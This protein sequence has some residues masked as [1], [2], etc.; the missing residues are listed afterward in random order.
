MRR[1]HALR[2][3]EGRPPEPK[4]SWKPLVWTQVA[5]D[6]FQA[7]GIPLLRGRYFNAQDGAESGPVAIVNETL[8][9]RY[10]PGEDPVGKRVKGFDPRGKHDDW[11]TVVGE[12]RDTR[13]GGLDKTPFSQMYEVQAQSGEQLG[14]LV[15]RTAGDPAPLAAAAR[16]LIHDADPLATV[17]SIESMEQLLD[18]QLMQRRFETWLIGV[19]SAMALALAALGVFAVMHYSVTAKRNEIGIRVAL[20]ARAG[21]IV[22]LI[23]SQG[24]QLACAG[25]AAGAIIAMWSTGAIRGMLYQVSATDPLTFLAAGLTL[26]AV[27]LFACFGPAQRASRIDPMAALR[28][29]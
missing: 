27:A 11:L 15:V 29:E 19:F 2:L 17:P 3:V 20:G 28:E 21:D 14:N 23:L 7:M 13:N 25:V 24:T 4:S 26:I 8:A 10:W 18:V 22:K 12:V 6:Y 9:R 1:T 5:G 16:K